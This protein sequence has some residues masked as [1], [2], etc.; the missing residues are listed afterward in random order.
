MFLAFGFLVFWLLVFLA[1]RLLRILCIPTSS[2]GLMQLLMEFG[3]GF[4]HPLLSQFL[5]SRWLLG[6]CGFLLVSAAFG[7][8]FGFGFWNSYAFPLPLRHVASWLLQPFVGS[9][10]N[11]FGFGSITSSSRKCFCLNIFTFMYVVCMYYVI[12]VRMPTCIH[13][14][15]YVK[16]CARLFVCAEDSPLSGSTSPKSP[17]SPKANRKSVVQQMLG[18]WAI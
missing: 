4:L 1:S 14:C 9:C 12:Y 7:G 18:T 15:M 6:F 13:F 11:M 3:F 5:S 17:Q 2:L 10:G 8:C 16:V